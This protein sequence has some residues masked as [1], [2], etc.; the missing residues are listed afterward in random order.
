M[1]SHSFYESDNRIIRYA[2]ALA[3]RGD[4]VVVLA[5]SRSPTLPRMEVINGVTLHRIQNRHVK[6]DGSSWS[7][8]WPLLRFLCAATWWF[9][10]HGLRQPFTLVHVHNI[11]DF[12]VFAT[13]APRLRGAK[14]ILD[15]H[16]IVPEFFASKFGDKLTP[17]MSAALKRMERVSA[18]MA[19]HVILSNHLWLETYTQ[20]SAAAAKCSVFINHVDETIFRAPGQ[21]P[22]LASEASAPGMASAADSAA[23]VDAATLAAIDE[24]LIIFPGGLYV[25]Q[26]V[27][28]AVHAVDALRRTVPG[29]R[30]HIYGEGSAKASLE[31]L[32]SSL[33]L[34]EHVKFFAPMPLRRIAEVMATADIAVVPKRADSFGNEAYSTKIMEFM[35]LGVP[36]VVSDTRVDRYYFD[37][38]VVHF[39]P[40][41]D[42]QALADAVKSLLDDPGER[43]AMVARAS[44]YV[45]RHNWSRHKLDYL[46]LVDTLVGDAPHPLR[47]HEPMA[48]PLYD[49]RS[50]R[51]GGR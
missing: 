30:F 46:R 11:P 21:S 45:A 2:E 39:F 29:V 40:S 28:I 22:L 16:D 15:I 36:V 27:D 32:V 19:N 35:S 44:S 26:G 12:L 1:V 49:P 3:E 7:Y 33:G 50:G 38:S 18:A 5:L 48:G 31:A 37:A 14:V 24:P 51:D 6:K 9:I 13:L 42:A 34:Q 10:R 17:M 23:A 25:H 43:A 41:G 47:V 20:R 8:L 4:E